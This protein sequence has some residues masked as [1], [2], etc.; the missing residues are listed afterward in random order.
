MKTLI[1][2]L[3]L[4][5]LGTC[6]AQ[7]VNIPDINFKNALVNDNVVD[8]DGDYIGDID[9][10]SNDDGEIQI[11]EAEAVTALMIHEKDIGSL[12][13]LDSFINLIALGAANNL[14]T[15]IDVSNNLLLE[16]L[17]IPDNALT[18]IDL[19][20]NVNLLGTNLRGSQITSLDLTNNPNM[21]YIFFEQSTI[22]SIDF[23]A[24]VNMEIIFGSDNQLTEVDLSNCLNLETAYLYNGNIEEINLPPTE[25]F[26]YLFIQSNPVT[27]IDITQNPVLRVLEAQ[28]TSISE[29]DTS[30]NEFLALLDI[31]GTMVTELDV[32]GNDNLQYL[33]FANTEISEIDLFNNNSLLALFCE[34]SDLTA[35]DLSS[36]QFLGELDC[37]GNQLQS[38]NLKNTI[39][40][41]MNALNN[42]ELLCIEVSNVEYAENS[43][44]WFKDSFAVYSEDCSLGINQNT[45]LTS[46]II[47][48]PIPAND[49]LTIDSP[50]LGQKMSI[51]NTMGQMVESNTNSNYINVGELPTGMYFLNIKIN[52]E[53]VIKPFIKE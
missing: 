14:F 46:E 15:E 52:N 53:N 20:Q 28:F 29:I 27:S 22:S 17:N 23:S 36:N 49:Q 1:I 2:P 51:Y 4:L 31:S 39:L 25:T 8:T 6:K 34:Y 45:I 50:Y 13:G 43:P 10:D 37:Q 41:E 11:S 35:L 24:S 47:L 21:Y 30:Q 48:Y 16:H 33:V 12:E 7:I 19:S 3:A 40:T 44:N 42:P 38:L 9:V 18:E 26:Q 5:V 32:T